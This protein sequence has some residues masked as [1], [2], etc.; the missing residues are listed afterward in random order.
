MLGWT[1]VHHAGERR[2]VCRGGVQ[3][4]EQQRAARASLALLQ[5]FLEGKHLVVF[6]I[7]RAVLACP[8]NGLTTP[9]AVQITVE[10]PTFLG[11][12]LEVA[13][14]EEDLAAHQLTT[15]LVEQPVDSVQ[16]FGPRRLVAV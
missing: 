1:D 10:E 12:R 15:R 7:S 13:D 3:I 14:Q 6:P 16:S 8:R 9:T 2:A 5:V 4:E 11:Q